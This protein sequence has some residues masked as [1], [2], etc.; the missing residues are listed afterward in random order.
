MLYGADFSGH[1]SQSFFNSKPEF[2]FFP[3]TC[4]RSCGMGKK[5]PS[6]VSH[7]WCRSICWFTSVIELVPKPVFLEHREHVILNYTIGITVAYIAF[8]Y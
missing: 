6:E 7:K 1:C 5:A 3:R 4:Q 8:C 2:Y